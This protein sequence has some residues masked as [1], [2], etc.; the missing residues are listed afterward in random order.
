MLTSLSQNKTP[1]LSLR[2]PCLLLGVL[3]KQ[4]GYPVIPIG[5]SETKQDPEGPRPSPT[6]S[7]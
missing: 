6:S 2:L 1:T 3:S 7:V 5:D 4:L